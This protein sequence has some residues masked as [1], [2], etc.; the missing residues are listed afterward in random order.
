MSEKLSEPVDWGDVNWSDLIPRLLLYA[1]GRA[2]RCRWQGKLA[3][4]LPGGRDLHDVVQTAI[5]K[6][7]AGERNWN[8]E[9]CTLFQHFRGVID[10]E[11]NH[12]AVGLENRTPHI[13]DDEIGNI[14]SLKPSPEDETVWIREKNN[15]LEFL[16]RKN[17]LCYEIASIM[18]KDDVSGSIEIAEILSIS[19]EEIN[20][21]KKRLRRLISEYKNSEKKHVI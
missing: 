6:T 8:R 2:D 21:A 17:E 19:V 20:N 5:Q 4:K 11:I 7:L 15:L 3:G 13:P 1:K 10:S 12:L 14:A 16:S 18:L 9:K